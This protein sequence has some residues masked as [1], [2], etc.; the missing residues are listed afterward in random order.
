[1]ALMA[2]TLCVEFDCSGNG[3]EGICLG[4]GAAAGSPM[5]CAA[6]RLRAQREWARRD[7]TRGGRPR[8]LLGFVP[9]L[10]CLNGAGARG[11]F[12]Q[13]HRLVAWMTHRP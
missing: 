8:V 3:F 2:M 6:R 13:S 11:C 10:D 4:G 5:V 1:M 9:S 7:L 12:R